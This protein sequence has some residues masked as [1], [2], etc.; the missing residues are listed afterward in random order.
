MIEVSKA[1]DD[2]HGHQI[3]ISINKSQ[4]LSLSRKHLTKDIQSQSE[5]SLF[6]YDFNK[7]A[8]PRD[9]P[10]NLKNR[11]RSS[12]SVLETKVRN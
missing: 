2:D 1:E 6:Y 5:V 10:P 7:S 11:Q 4:H 12:V 3:K 9:Q 8:S